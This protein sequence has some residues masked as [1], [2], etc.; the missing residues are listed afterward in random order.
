MTEYLFKSGAFHKMV[1]PE[2]K[3]IQVQS[4]QLI[5][6]YQ[7]N[8]TEICFYGVLYSACYGA[9]SLQQCHSKRSHLEQWQTQQKHIH[10]LIT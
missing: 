8:L 2:K 5:I 10:I 7:F 1:L 6:N 3:E 4:A 9:I